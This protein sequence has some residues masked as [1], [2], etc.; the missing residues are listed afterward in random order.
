M[1][2][3]EI[4]TCPVPHMRFVPSTCLYAEPYVDR[5]RFDI[6]RDYRPYT[7]QGGIICRSTRI[8]VWTAC[9]SASTG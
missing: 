7:V 9:I 2:L 5:E 3:I 1:N 8:R 4:I 6:A